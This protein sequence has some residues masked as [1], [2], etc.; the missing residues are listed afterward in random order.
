MTSSPVGIWRQNDVVS[1]SIRRDDVASTLILRHVPAGRVH[2]QETACQAH[3][4]IIIIIV[5]IIIMIIIIIIIRNNVILFG[6]TKLFRAFILF[7]VTS[8]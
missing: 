4:S 7:I 2:F 1:T 3:N 8:V 5:I 6:L